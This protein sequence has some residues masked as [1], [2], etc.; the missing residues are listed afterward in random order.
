MGIL[1]FDIGGSSVKYAYA[2]DQGILSDRGSIPVCKNV[3]ENFLEQLTLIYKEYDK[4]YGIEGIAVSAPG[5]VDSRNGVIHGMS[6]VPCIHEIPFTTLLSEAMDRK[7]VI[8]ENDGNCGVMGEFWKGAAVGTDS[9]AIVVCGT[10]IGG[11][12]LKDGRVSGGRHFTAY[13]FGFMPIVR[14]NGEIQPWSNYSVGNTVKQYNRDMG[15][16]LTGVELFGLAE[17]DKRAAFYVERF[18]HYLAVGCMSVGFALDPDVL[19]VGGAVSRRY[20]FKDRFRE[21]YDNL[22][23]M[24]PM[25]EVCQ[26]NMVVSELGNDANLYGALYHY[27]ISEKEKVWNEKLYSLKNF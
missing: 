12:Y 5:A 10:G 3:W 8:V 11:G 1:V 21:A 2:A 14:E 22:K 26:S 6:A 4:H 18:Y 19:V 24:N 23:A 16:A 15:T 9:A 27:L 20:D 7:R 17:T 13:E 25:F